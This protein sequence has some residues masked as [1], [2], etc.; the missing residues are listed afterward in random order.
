MFLNQVASL[1]KKLVVS[2]A[3]GKQAL[4]GTHRHSARPSFFPFAVYYAA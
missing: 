1:W 4:M 3:G 2:N